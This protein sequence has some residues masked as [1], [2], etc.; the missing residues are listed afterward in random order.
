MALA[1]A[2]GREA[3]ATRRRR[4]AADMTDG[5]EWLPLHDAAGRILAQELRTSIP[6]PHY[7][8]SA[9]D[10]YA[11]A[12]S[13]SADTPATFSPLRRPRLPHRRGSSRTGPEWTTSSHPAAPA[14]W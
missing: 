11:Y 14:R 3:L 7:P 6:V 13:S 8:S 12:A 1:H 4:D 9:M 2:L 5:M 10:G